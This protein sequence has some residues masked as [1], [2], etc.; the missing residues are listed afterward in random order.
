M[1]VRE[2]LMIGMNQI[3]LILKIDVKLNIELIKLQKRKN[4]VVEI[5]VTMVK[6]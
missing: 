5:V 6:Q 2:G 1:I 3:V 4:L